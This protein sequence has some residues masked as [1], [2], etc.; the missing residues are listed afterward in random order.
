MSDEVKVLRNAAPTS[1][2]NVAERAADR[3]TSVSNQLLERGRQLLVARNIEEFRSSLRQAAE[4]G[5]PSAALLLGATYDPVEIK[6][7]AIEGASP[8]IAS[9]RYWYEKAKELGSN[10]AVKRLERLSSRPR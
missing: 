2:A 9:A 8:D 4:M 10:D 6:E 5:N 7:L 1:P 3:S